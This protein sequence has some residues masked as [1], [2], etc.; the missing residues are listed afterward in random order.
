MSTSRRAYFAFVVVCLVWGTTYLAIRI[1]LGSSPADVMRLVMGGGAKMGLVGLAVGLVLALV[2]ARIM[3]SALP[4][5]G[6]PAM[7][8]STAGVKMRMRTSVSGEDAA[9]MNVVSAKFISR[10]ISCMVRSGRPAASGK[11]ASWLPP[12]RRSVKTSKWR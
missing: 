12:N 2:L 7:G 11:I 5:T 8:I 6:C 9:V 3:K 4:I 1:A 10:A